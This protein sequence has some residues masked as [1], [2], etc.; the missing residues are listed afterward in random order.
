M[1]TLAKAANAHLDALTASATP[2]TIRKYRQILRDRIIPTF[3]PLP[4]D[5]ITRTSVEQWIGNLR[6][7][8]VG[9]GAAKKPP[10][11]KTLRNAQALLSAILQRQVDEGVLARNV[12]KGVPLPRDTVSP[13]RWRPSSRPPRRTTG[14]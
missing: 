7:T 8:P 10:S 14:P 3:G 6:A 11:A 2:G 4:V 9:R 13:P 1:P 5:T 12:A